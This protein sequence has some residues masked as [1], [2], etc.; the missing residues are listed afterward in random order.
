MMA[1]TIK[2]K[3]N[4]NQNNSEC[5][6][7]YINIV[8]DAYCMFII[9]A[10]Q[11]ANTDII[12]WNNSACKLFFYL[13]TGFNIERKKGAAGSCLYFTAIAGLIE[14]AFIFLTENLFQL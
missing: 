1:G 5:I 14:Y 10:R 3:E 11:R 9:V 13:E 8:C 7:E 2:H 6:K 12:R 4:C